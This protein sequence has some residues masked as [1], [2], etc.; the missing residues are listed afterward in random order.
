MVCYIPRWLVSCVTVVT[1]YEV[2]TREVRELLTVRDGTDPTLLQCSILIWVLSAI[3]FQN[4]RSQAS[5]LGF[6]LGSFNVV[7]TMSSVPL[8]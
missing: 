8:H 6:G 3:K 2:T 5:K 7:A 4:S 1:C